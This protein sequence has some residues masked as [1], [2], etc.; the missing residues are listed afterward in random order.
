MP[1]HQPDDKAKVALWD[2][3]WSHYYVT[4]ASEKKDSLSVEYG[5][6]GGAGVAGGAGAC[7]GAMRNEEDTYSADAAEEALDLTDE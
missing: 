2:G 3:D 7:T 1:F 4:N 5:A 6:A